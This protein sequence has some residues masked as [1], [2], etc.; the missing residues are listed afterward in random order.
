MPF[1]DLEPIAELLNDDYDYDYDEE[2]RRKRS[3]SNIID[4]YEYYDKH[5]GDDES[6]M[7]K[8]VKRSSG[9]I[10]LGFDPSIDLYPTD[11]CHLIQ[12]LTEDKCLENSLLELW[13]E[14]NYGEE[15]DELL[16]TITEEEIIRAVNSDTYSKVLGYDQ[17]FTKFLGGIERN[18]SGHIVAAKA[19]F[20]R[21]FGKVNI[22]AIT[23]DDRSSASKGS[24][25]DQYSLRWETSLIETLTKGLGNHSGYDLFPNVAK[26]FNDLSAEAIEGDAFIFGCGTA[27]M[28]IYVQLMLGKFN[29]VE[30]RPGLSMVGIACCFL[31]LLTSYGICSGVGLVFSPMHAII[32]F[33]FVGIGIDDMFVIVQC[34]ANIVK[35]AGDKSHLEIMSLTLKEAGVAITIT[36]ITNIIVFA[37]GAVTVLPALQSFCV[38]CAVG[39]AAIYIYQ[40]TI[41]F[42]AMSIDQKRIDGRRNGLLPCIKHKNW[43]PNAVSKRNFAQEI[44][45]K[46]A[47]YQL[48]WAGKL[49]VIL[50]T[51]GIGSVGVWGLTMLR[52]EFNPVWF[53]P[54]ESYLAQW[55]H[56]NEKYF[57]KEG[58]T[59]KINIAQI[60]YS[61]ELP[62]LD[63]LVSRLEEETSILTNVDSWY[64]KFKEYTVTNNLVNETYGWFDVFREDKN[65]F[66][67]VLTQFLFSSSGA[68]Y[69]GNFNF[70]QDLVCGEQASEIM[71]RYI[72]TT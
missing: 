64:R 19:T 63:A 55:F 39:I 53:I 13:T 46:L 24:P 31:G 8:R 12:D 21:F 27:I 45:V 2:F 3:V 11:Y 4:D 22:S 62:K 43:E 26:S 10:D 16:D 35:N 59:V 44:F 36:S 65:K 58:E 57:P 66:Y 48:H 33:L 20:I 23:K 71:V 38:Y 40:A 50:V 60:D 41:F 56:A 28:F 69:R 34:H 15:T 5:D 68:K 18:A 17:D 52:Q 70:M 7:A 32:P 51:L 72:A 47:K 67:R 14:D 30:Q 49:V 25:V 9:K 54:Q 61:N 37:V 42:A 29:F 1:I 6:D